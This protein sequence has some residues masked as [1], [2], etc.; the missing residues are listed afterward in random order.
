MLEHEADIALLHRLLRGI[1][2]A[3]EDRAVGRAFEPCDQPQQRCLAGP[4]RAEQGDE[5]AGADIE[6]H[7]LES[8]KP[9]EFLA[10]VLNA[11]F[12]KTLYLFQCLRAAAICALN[13]NSSSDLMTSVTSARSA[14]SVA[15]A[16]A[17][18]KLYSL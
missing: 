14:S 3:E 11:Y 5:L 16:K 1:G 13:L 12:H 8:R 15:T 2:V 7:L 6:R 17:P 9:A 4:G 10:N 18:T